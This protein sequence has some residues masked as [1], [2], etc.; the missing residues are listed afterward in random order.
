MTKHEAPSRLC[1][2]GDLA[3]E[4]LKLLRKKGLEGR[5]R[6]PAGTGELVTGPARLGR[7]G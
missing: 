7:R 1:Q 5:K 4:V 3:V 6:Q 2:K